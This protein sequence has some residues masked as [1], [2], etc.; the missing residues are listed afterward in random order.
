ML[1][2]LLSS[3]LQ[4]QVVYTA[5]AGF[6]MT[7]DPGTCNAMQ[8]DCGMVTV[9]TLTPGSQGGKPQMVM[10]PIFY[11][12]GYQPQL[13]QVA[14]HGA[15]ATGY[16]PQQVEMPPPYELEDYNVTIIITK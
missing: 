3:I 15:M 13:A 7:Q 6:V 2:F 11:V 12:E 10:V 9:E 5:N 8:A 16:Q 1:Y 4:G 14:P